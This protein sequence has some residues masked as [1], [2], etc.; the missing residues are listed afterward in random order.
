MTV[1]TIDIRIREDGSRVVKRNL[2]EIGETGRRSADGIDFL[3]RALGLLGAGLAVQRV[4]QY[5]DAWAQAAGQ[6]AIATRT[7]AEAAVVTERLFAA[8]QRTRTGFNDIAELYARV[9]RVGGELGTTQER[10]IQFTEG[11]GK[12]LAVQGTSAVNAR[13]AL[14][15]LGQALGSGI[16][17]AEEFNSILEG[18]PSILQVVA[19]NIEGVN[20]SIAKLRKLLL[21]GKLTSQV[22]F[23]AFMKGQDELNKQFA[24]A[25]LTFSQSF[26]IINNALSK[27][28][29]E[30]DKALGVSRLFGIA[31]RFVADN[32]KELGSALL[33]L[34]TVLAVV[35][36]IRG[37]IAFTA[38]LKTLFLL[39]AANPFVALAAG[40]AGALVYL[41]QFAD[42]IDVGIAAGVTLQDL[43]T[44]IA[45]V[46][47]TS[48][49][50]VREAAIGAFTGLAELATSVYKVVTNATDE[51]A[52]TW[53][54][55]YADFYDGVGS[56]FGG[57]VKAVARTLDAIG[58]LIIGLVISVKRIVAPIPSLFG[59]AF[60]R[61]YNIA[62]DIV[63]QLV[64]YTISSINRLRALVGKD[65]VDLVKIPRLEVNESAF[66]EYGQGIA[67][68]IDE[69]FRIQG[70]FLEK[71]VDSLFDRAT[72]AADKRL[73]DLRRKL[74]ESGQVDL[75]KKLGVAAKPTLDEKE[76]QKL[77]N[78][79]RQLLNEIAPVEGAIL[80][81]KR[82]QEVLNAAQRAGLITT[83]QQARYL[84]LLGE[85]YKDI[86]DPLG[87]VNR[88]LDQ[89][90]ALLRLNAREREVQSQ[91]LSIEADLRNRGIVLSKDERTE[92]AAKLQQMQSLND[93]VQAQDQLL[94]QSVAARQAF[95]TQ[96]VA[97]QSLLADPT[98]GFGKADAIQAIS[99]QMP[100]LLEGTQELLDA[101]VAQ[102]QQMYAQIDELRQRDIISH[103]TAEQLKA[104]VALE[105]NQTRLAYTQTFFGNLATLS[106][107][108]NRK[109]AA[110]GRAAAVAQATIDGIL[111]V[112]K[113]LASAPPPVNYVLAAAVGAAAAANVANILSNKGFMEGGF[114]GNGPIN[115]VAGVV[116]GQEFV[117]NAQSTA[118]N[119]PLLEHLNR[120]GDV[121]AF[122][123]GV[124]VK[125]E[126]YGTS[127][128]YE[129]QQLS[130]NEVRII[131]RDEAVNVVQNSAAAVVAA[132]MNDPNSRTSKALNRNLNAQR[133][134]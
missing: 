54:A 101:Q 3:K 84:Q 107:S 31:A 41:S 9:A 116:H 121:S 43:F 114:T 119:R 21:D 124:E 4:I 23:E 58:G 122:G 96:L 49:Y 48:F 123:G 5:A 89:Q 22:F 61:S 19:N 75:N 83:E 66:K 102:Y 12:A 111:A 98:S 110:I 44:A 59:E 108:G 85:R 68:S 93:R 104:K 131:A 129:V 103:Q 79:L 78:A 118:R 57:V 74:E 29:G 50:T 80:E 87:A 134:R 46:A 16:V 25:P 63:E 27:Y 128:Q 35:F 112:Q 91:L 40:I 47:V 120:G 97:L 73:R 24:K 67:E 90:S 60:S 117:N 109:V 15:Q 105:Q 11:I 13:G 64:N 77:S 52:A 125:I 126:N 8:A 65:L 81:M 76:A 20:G 94:A 7:T 1:E 33:A 133:K 38:A 69:G 10:L 55:S 34:G 115:K 39:V 30:L 62:V 82:A 51:A 32:M 127:K 45:E 99:Q 28:I 26:T 42:Q 100:G 6:I 37:I 132:D 88:E 36:S 17:R 2:Q 92:L 71:S 70:N 14:L 130:A 113:A 56:G 72:A 86:I 106:R 95:T 53:A 18:A